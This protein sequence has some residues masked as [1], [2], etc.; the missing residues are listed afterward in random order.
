METFILLKV[1]IVLLC[2]I[3]NRERIAQGAEELFMKY[4]IKSIT[5]DEI[6]TH[7]SVSKKTI[8]QHFKDKDELV[9]EVCD[10][11]MKHEISEMDRIIEES[12]NAIEEI[13]K[14]S[15]LIR[16]I[17]SKMNPSL[18][19]DLKKYH[20]K[21][22]KIYEDHKEECMYGS[23]TKN[24]EQGKKEG[25]YRADINVEILSRLRMQQVEWGLDASV[26]PPSAF[27]LYEIQ[28]QLFTHFLFGIITPAGWEL[29]QQYVA[30][31]N[32]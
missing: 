7:L 3:D 26:F 12:S 11:H 16:D 23:I 31:N 19:F 22:W 5:M 10:V 4:G 1:S 32:Q 25:Y 9:C 28:A 14:M 2:M 15:M 13:F 17:S 20:P 24:L 8:Y 21:A 29:F 27:T 6:A 18:L 30:E